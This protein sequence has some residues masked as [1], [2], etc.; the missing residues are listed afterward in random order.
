MTRSGSSIALATFAGVACVLALPPGWLAPISVTATLAA[1]VSLIVVRFSTRTEPN[2]KRAVGLL[3]LV[4]N[5]PEQPFAEVKA[6][7]PLT[8]FLASASFLL[9]LGLAVMVRAYA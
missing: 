6:G 2:D 3:F 7:W 1:T 4:M 9:A 8:V 5:L